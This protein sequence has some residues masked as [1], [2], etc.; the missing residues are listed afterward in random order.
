M[1]KFKR[2]YDKNKE[3]YNQERKNKYENDEDYRNK[4]L[5]NN[6]SYREEN[7]KDDFEFEINGQIVSVML[8]TS[9]DVAKKL[10]C[11]ITALRKWE[12][13]GIIP[14]SPLKDDKNIRYYT[15]NFIDL[16]KEI[17]KAQNIFKDK[18]IN[19]AF[20]GVNYLCMNHDINL[21]QQKVFFTIEALCD[22]LNITRAEYDAVYINKSFPK[23]KTVNM[24]G[25]IMY[26][27]RMINYFGKN[28]KKIPF[29]KNRIEKDNLH[30]YVGKAWIKEGKL[31]IVKPF[32]L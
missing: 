1:S 20:R 5:E 2:W 14:E 7:K 31:T 28:I 24:Q 4:Q 17:L 18:K 10:N 15:D 16:I 19:K 23:P 21:L 9:N 26:T 3:K 29:I 13:K 25:E 8:Y 27:Q 22:Q 11:S 32:E 30:R 12:Q 6:K